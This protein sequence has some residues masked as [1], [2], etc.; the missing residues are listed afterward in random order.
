MMKYGQICQLQQ[1]TEK[2][3]QTYLTVTFKKIICFSI[4]TSDMFPLM[5]LSPEWKFE[6]CHMT[7]GNVNNVHL[8]KE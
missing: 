2:D 6:K 4:R 1:P 8:K 3:K 7:K 5:I